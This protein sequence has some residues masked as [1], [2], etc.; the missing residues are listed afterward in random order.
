MSLKRT[1]G[2]IA[3]AL[4]AATAAAA[5]DATPAASG[6]LPPLVSSEFDRGSGGVI[7]VL[8]KH[9]AP[10]SGSLSIAGSRSLGAFGSGNSGRGYGATLGGSLVQDRVWFFASAERSDSS[11]ATRYAPQAGSSIPNFPRSD[12]TDARMTAQIGSRQSLAALFATTRNSGNTLGI[13]APQNSSFLSLHYTGVVSDNM[14]FNASFSGLR[15]D[16]R[17]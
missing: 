11:F 6:M 5:Q 3:L 16:S 10:L 14:F 15:A 12:A 17:N 7:D 1:A 4:M 8:A 13:F 2:T 9:G